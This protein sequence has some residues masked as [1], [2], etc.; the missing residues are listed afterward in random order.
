MAWVFITGSSDGLGR[1]A[2]KL[3]VEQGHTVVLHARNDARARVA[4]S[5]VP[6]AEH[7]LVADFVSLS[8]VRRLAK[9]ANALGCFD[10][11]IHNAAVGYR[12]KARLQTED[13]IS[14][15][16]AINTL[17]PNMLGAELRIAS[18]TTKVV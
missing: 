7:V 1:N 5:A 12:E 8:Q 10:A 18:C 9:D 16:F 6:S 2:A 4:I 17:A 13:G 14:H 3:L 15:V 11:I